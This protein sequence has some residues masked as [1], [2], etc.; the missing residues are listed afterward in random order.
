MARKTGRPQ[1]IPNSEVISIRFDSELFALVKDIASLECVVTGRQVSAHE[2]IRNA[3]QFV[4]GDNER[5][6]EVFRRMKHMNKIRNPRN[7]KKSA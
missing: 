6:R 2:L 7:F 4:Y 5:M 1:S 3:V